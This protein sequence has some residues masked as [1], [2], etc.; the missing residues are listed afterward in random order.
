MGNVLTCKQIPLTS[1]SRKCREISLESLY[2]DIGALRVNL[3]LGTPETCT[4]YISYHYEPN[5]KCQRFLKHVF[6]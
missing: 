4:M 5:R 2:V 6:L 3:V 1:S